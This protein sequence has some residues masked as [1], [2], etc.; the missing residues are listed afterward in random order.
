MKAVARSFICWPGIDKDIEDFCDVYPVLP[1]EK[2]HQRRLSNRGQFHRS[3]GCV[4]IWIMDP[5]QNDN[6][7]PLTDVFY[8]RCSGNP[9]IRQRTFC[10]NRGINHIY[11]ASC[12]PQSNGLKERILD[13]L[14]RSLRKI[15]SGG[16]TLEEALHVF[17]H[18]YRT[19]PP[20]DL[21]GKSPAEMMPIRTVS[22]LLK[23][24]TEI[25]TTS[26]DKAEK[27]NA[28]FNKKHSAVKRQF[29]ARETVYALVHQNNM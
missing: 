20:S 27:Q 4:S 28:A 2:V 8:T 11:T 9:R 18:V 21:G 13:T 25:S 29:A 16:R 17:L 15:H 5:L 26:C 10:E 14:R 23:P 6:Q 12:Q 1:Q 19:T 24:L 7:A 22:S 3:L